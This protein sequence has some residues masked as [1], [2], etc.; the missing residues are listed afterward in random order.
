MGTHIFLHEM[1][2]HLAP[3]DHMTNFG[4]DTSQAAFDGIGFQA[5]GG[6]PKH[7]YGMSSNHLN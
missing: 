6:G 1:A 2:Y 5:Q 7:H 3:R 4:T